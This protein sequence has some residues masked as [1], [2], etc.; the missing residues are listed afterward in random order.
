MRRLSGKL[1]L[2]RNNRQNGRL[3]VL[4]GIFLLLTAGAGVR[5]G[6]VGYIFILIGGS[7]LVVFGATE[8]LARRGLVINQAALRK[9]LRPTRSGC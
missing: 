4:A 9:G 8:L 6:D 1:G 7:A 2:G 3:Y 5:R